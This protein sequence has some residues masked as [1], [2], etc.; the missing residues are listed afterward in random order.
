M[1]VT[2]IIRLRAKTG[3][4]QALLNAFTGPLNEVRQHPTCLYADMFANTE[5]ND[6][7]LLLEEWETADDHRKYVAEIRA[8]GIVDTLMKWMAGPPETS[9]H[10]LAE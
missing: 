8:S 1:S 6:E 9:Y 4:G 5:R 3:Q 7:L 2:A 10:I